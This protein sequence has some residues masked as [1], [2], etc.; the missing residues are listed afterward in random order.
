MIKRLLLFLII[1]SG[2]AH[3]QFVTVKATVSDRNNHLYANCSWHVTFLGDPSSTLN[4]SAFDQ[5][6]SGSCTPDG[7]FALTLPQS[8]QIHPLGSQWTFQFCNSTGVFCASTPLTVGHSDPQD[9]SVALRSVAPILPSILPY[10]DLV[11]NLSNPS[12]PDYGSARIFY[13][14]NTARV[15]AIDPSGANVLFG[16]GGGGGVSSIATTAPI[17][18]G[19]ITSTGTI[20]CPACAMGPG[21]SVAG[22][23]AIFSGTNGLTLAD[24]GVSSGPPVLLSPTGDQTIA[25]AYQLINLGTGQ[26]GT[27][28][29]SFDANIHSDAYDPAS[30]NV[31]ISSQT[32]GNST[33]AFQ[34]LAQGASAISFFGLA[35]TIDNGSTAPAYAGEFDTWHTT[36]AD[37]SEPVAS[38]DAALTLTPAVGTTMSHRLHGAIEYLVGNEGLGTVDTM[39]GAFVALDNSGG[40]TVNKA[41]GYDA[42]SIASAGTTTAVFHA[43]DQGSGA[44]NYGILLEGSTHNDLGAGLTKVGSLSSGTDNSSAGSVTI[45]NGSSNAHTIFTSGA[46]TTNTIAG[47]ATVPTTGHIVTCTVSGTTCTLTDG[48]AP[49]GAGTVTSI[50]TT[51]PI[52]GGTITTTGTIACATCGVTGSPLSQF[53][54][55]TSSQLAG[56]ISDETGS[57][58]LV[59]GTAPTFTTSI[60][61]P[62]LLTTTKCAAAGTAANPSVAACSAAP[63]GSFSCATNA[64]TGTCTVNT[65]A[66]T[67]ASAIFVQPDSS[68]SSLLSVTCNTTADSG[69]TAPRVS[70]RSAA[71]SFTIT[72]GTFATNPVCFN[73][74]IVN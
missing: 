2:F 4:G 29:A 72:L 8:S 38:V 56:V 26:T 35:S 41:Y 61:T 31:R 73:Y 37:S 51:G 21:T 50:A 59:F 40:G 57:G 55:T 3:A 7:Y 46:T 13:N 17:I 5:S 6:F 32:I 68:L 19:P 28:Y 67:A 58:V 53:A 44:T 42:Q 45:A 27:P 52:T 16:G 69:L 65:S 66:V 47:F 22:H 23:I 60:T 12:N 54:A 70:A 71:T 63:S 20:S 24:G 30:G 39:Q 11:A 62:I 1:V 64:S 14:Q 43:S 34:G 48:G 33:A 15:E 36:S 10:L 9:I 25:G 18:G 49:G 74:W